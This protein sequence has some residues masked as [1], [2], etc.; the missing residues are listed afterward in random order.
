MYGLIALGPTTADAA[1]IGVHLRVET[2]RGRLREDI[3]RM[4]AWELARRRHRD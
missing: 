1:G 4:S 3:T 2:F